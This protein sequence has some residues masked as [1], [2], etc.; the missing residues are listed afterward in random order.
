MEE[1]DQKDVKTAATAAQEAAAA[2]QKA[3]ETAAE[4]AAQHAEL[5]RKYDALQAQA[6]Q[7]ETLHKQAIGL[8]QAEVIFGR[9]DSEM[10]PADVAPKAGQKT[11]Y[12]ICGHLFQLLERWQFGGGIAISLAELNHHSLAKGDTQNLM[13][14]LLGTQ[15]W[16]GWFGKPDFVMAEESVLPRQL[17]TFLHLALKRLKTHYEAVEE[18]MAAAAKAYELLA[19]ASAKKRKTEHQ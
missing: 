11:F 14:K 12:K 16:E 15:L 8:Q 13:R 5:Q 17:L 3:E 2:T 19:E 10:I 9:A 7:A 1:V 6:A 4:V 18:A